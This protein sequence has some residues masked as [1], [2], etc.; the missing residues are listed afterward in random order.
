MNKKIITVLS[1]ILI[2]TLAIGSAYL[3]DRSRMNSNK[4]VI[5]STW[6]YDYA[7]PEVLGKVVKITD[8]SINTDTAFAMALEKIYED[9]ENEYY[10]NCIKSQYIIVEY[11]NGYKEDVKTA[12]N[13]GNIALVDLNRFGIGYI[14]EK[15]EIDTKQAIYNQSGEVLSI[16]LP[17]NWEYEIIEEAS[18]Q[19]EYGI[20][21]YLADSEK[22]AVL[23]SYKSLFGVCGTG[24]ECKD[25]V[26]NNG[27]TATI[28]Y[29]D[30]NEDWS[31]MTFDY[32][33]KE[34]VGMNNGLEAEDA[35]EA[36]EIL[37]T[38]EY[39]KSDVKESFIGTI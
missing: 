26:L 8:T 27:T 19:Y 21:F 5:F 23:Y 6:G 32:N 37:K 16:T 13:S 24:L 17:E 35:K 1:I 22:H 20:K 18:E 39:K 12:L 15:K 14:T 34:I 10:F 29:Y 25:I 11:E 2:F 31:F 33:D 4:P 7:P 9:I 30:N 28:G 3:I 38:L 36:L